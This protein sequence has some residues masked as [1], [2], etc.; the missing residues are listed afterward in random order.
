MNM[1]IM[2]HVYHLRTEME[3]KKPTKVPKSTPKI[4]IKLLLY[5]KYRMSIITGKMIEFSALT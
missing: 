2:Y 3:D 5:S 1:L 4:L